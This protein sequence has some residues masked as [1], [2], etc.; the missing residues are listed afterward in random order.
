MV[1]R[2]TLHA[3]RDFSGDGGHGKTLLDNDQTVG[4]FDAFYDGVEIK[5]ADGDQI[6]D[7]RLDALFGQ[8]VGRSMDVLEDL[9]C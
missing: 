8:F 4:L 7:L 5:R 6:D 3:V 9:V 1:E 2:V